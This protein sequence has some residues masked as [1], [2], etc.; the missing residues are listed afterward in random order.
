MRARRILDI[1]SIRLEPELSP[2]EGLTLAR[3]VR[4]F[5]RGAYF[6]AH[7]TLEILW[8]GLRGP[9]RDFLQ[10]LIQV[11]VGFH[12]LGRG[13][14]RGAGKMFVKALDRFADYPEH[15][16]GF[17]LAAERTRLRALVA[18]LDRGEAPT[19]GPD[20]AWRFAHPPAAGD[21]QPFG[22]DSGQTGGKKTR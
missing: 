1:V 12:H 8:T 4:E 16:F 14:A 18:A 7:E 19:R 5:N 3:A 9:S 22:V 6:D 11:S 13:N 21:P 10:G 17:D 2:E 20:A 15:Y